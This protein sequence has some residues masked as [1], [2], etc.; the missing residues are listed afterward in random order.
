MSSSSPQ[1]ISARLDETF[2]EVGLGEDTR[3][4]LG[5]PKLCVEASIPLRMDDGSL[6]IFQGF[7]VRHNDTR[8]PAKG[9]IRFHPDVNRHEVTQLAFWMTF[10][11][12]LNNLPFGGAK[13][14]VVVDVDELSTRELESLSRGYIDAFADVIGPLVDIPAPDLYTDATI[15]G[16]MADEFG[17]V[18]RRKTL[19]SFTGKPVPMGGSQGR[20]GATARGAY[21]LIRAVMKREKRDPKATTVAIQGFGS[22]GG[23]LARMLA[24]DGFNI[25]A[26]SDST[27]G[28]F[29]G[30]G[31]AVDTIWQQ[32]QV[33]QIVDSVYAAATADGGA[34]EELSNAEL[35]ALDVDILI[36]AAMGDAIDGNNAGDVQAD[37]IFEVANGPVTSAAD[38]ILAERQITVYPGIWVNAGGVTVSYFEWMQN[39]IDAQWSADE[40]AQRLE[41][42]ILN[43]AEEVFDY[44]DD[45]GLPP[46]IAA[47]ALALERL[48]DAVQA[49][50][51][52]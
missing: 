37:L 28:V 50:T 9:G 43:V 35:L 8:G 23:A 7:R 36:P 25:V 14:G 44:M 27:G 21:H 6:R 13:G 32:K 17:R 30:D 19:E 2:A 46:R 11:C 38:T 12:A 5:A 26:V 24:M 34:G 41:E 10:K 42:R 16:W 18:R 45:T 31:L 1:D 47:Y 15:M 3:K 4:M 48:E 49:A 20:E 40:V 22:A 39:R 33:D 51:G 29:H 52:R